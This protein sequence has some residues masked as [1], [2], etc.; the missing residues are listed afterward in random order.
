M[1][2]NDLNGPCIH[3]EIKHDYL[4]FFVYAGKSRAVLEY[5]KLPFNVRARSL[6]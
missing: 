4:A 6:F 5:H 2:K 1:N 3:R